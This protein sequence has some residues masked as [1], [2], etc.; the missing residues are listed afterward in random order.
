MLNPIGLVPKFYRI[1]NWILSCY[2]LTGSCTVYIFTYVIYMKYKMC[3]K[4]LGSNASVK[5]KG[6][7]IKLAYWPTV[8]QCGMGTALL[9][10]ARHCSGWWK[11]PICRH[12]LI[13]SGTVTWYVSESPTPITLCLLGMSASPGVLRGGTCLVSVLRRSHLP[14]VLRVWS[15]R[16]PHGPSCSYKGFCGPRRFY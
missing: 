9:R 11:L 1:L 12:G 7:L 5:K 2:F 13:P 10:S 14:L 16:R 3:Q 15:P 4:D 6:N 8:S